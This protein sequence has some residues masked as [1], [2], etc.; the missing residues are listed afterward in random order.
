MRALRRFAIA[1]SLLSICAA[2]PA[3]AQS[4][5]LYFA[6]YLGL[7]VMHDED[8]SESTAG[9][10]GSLG[11]NNAPSF[12]GAL[13][14][15]LTPNIRVEGELTYR[16]NSASHMNFANGT[17]ARA[18]GDLRAYML[19]LNMY[20][21]FN[22]NWHNVTPYVTAGVGVANFRGSV[23]SGAPA[24][25]P[26]SDGTDTV[27]AYQAGTGLKYRVSPD[28]AL[29]GGYRYV[30]TADADIGNYKIHTG[31]H[32]FRLGLEYDLPVDWMK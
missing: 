12:A 4:S 9:N 15:R 13:G 1:A 18:G 2:A 17:T 8:F 27:F 24:L 28:M 5:R 31:A 25:A 26:S 11:Y 16:N 30:G 10:S 32:E 19:M 6:G 21:D 3:L 20:Y 29:T 14:L 22:F 7:N 23:S